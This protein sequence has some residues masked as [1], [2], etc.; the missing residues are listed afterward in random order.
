MLRTM[1]IADIAP[2][3]PPRAGRVRSARVT[4]VDGARTMVHVARHDLER[5]ELRVALLRGQA[6][7]EPWCAARGVQEALVGGFFVRPDGTPLGEVRTRGVARRYVP[8]AAPWD[9][10][11][12]CVHVRGGV[13][14]IARRDELP[15]E[16]R[17]D[18]L[19]AGPLLVRDGAPVFDRARDEE[20]FRAGQ[21]Q[22]DSD[23]TDGRHPR[24]ALGLTGDTLVAV[25]CDGRSRHDAGL[26][27]AEL[28]ALMAALGCRDALNLD[29]GGSTSLVSGG[30]LR[31]RP[32]GGWER[33]EPGG[34]PVSTALLFLPRE[35]GYAAGAAV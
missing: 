30:R 5:V 32:R 20:G 15:P 31:N 21:A 9:D 7:L 19:Q 16:P 17:G 3:R 11:R 25:A 18:L 14:G 12:A 2:L 23:I 29:G 10:V 22:F 26:T 4:L 6:R 34:R 8:F 24:A 13:A 35:P 33:P 28:A 27:L 1:A